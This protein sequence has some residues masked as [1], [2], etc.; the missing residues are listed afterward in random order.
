MGETMFIY[1]FKVHWIT[2]LNLSQR[3]DV[4]KWE[5][6]ETM[7]PTLSSLTNGDYKQKNIQNNNISII[8]GMHVE[9][10]TSKY[11]CEI[12]DLTK[13]GDL[14]ITFTTP[15]PIHTKE[16]LCMRT[17]T[18]TNIDKDYNNV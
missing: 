5:K 17:H 9:V 1:S 10:Y 4:I 2:Q 16:H 11:L 8:Y 18:H 12:A 7:S 6:G 14:S 15:A 13:I 3:V